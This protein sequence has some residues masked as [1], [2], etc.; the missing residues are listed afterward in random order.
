M[1][2]VKRLH[3]YVEFI[4]EMIKRKCQPAILEIPV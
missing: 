3:I 2:E 4:V 1:T